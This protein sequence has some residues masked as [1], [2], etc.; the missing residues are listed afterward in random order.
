MDIVLDFIE[1]NFD[2]EYWEIE[3]VP[4]LPK[5]LLLKNKNSGGSVL[6]WKDISNDAVCFSVNGDPHV[7]RYPKVMKCFKSCS[8]K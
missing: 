1:E 5:A 3:N 2:L 4:F 8:I 7:K 6:V